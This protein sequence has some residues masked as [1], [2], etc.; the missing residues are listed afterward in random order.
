MPL[1]QIFALLQSLERLFQNGR[2]LRGREDRCD[3]AV[4]FERGR[5]VARCLVDHHLLDELA[6]QVDEGLLWHLVA[7]LK[8]VRQKA[9]V[10]PCLLIASPC[11]NAIEPHT[12]CAI[13]E[14]RGGNVRLS[15]DLANRCDLRLLQNDRGLRPAEM[16]CLHRNSPLPAGI[17]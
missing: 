5:L 15:G 9:W 10:L 11:V 16:R 7:R 2:G 6:H 12:S 4:N 14:R 1:L 8:V 13:V 3:P 17:M